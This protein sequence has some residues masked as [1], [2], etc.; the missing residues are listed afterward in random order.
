MHEWKKNE[1][2]KYK[3]KTEIGIGC[4]GVRTHTIYMNEACV[5]FHLLLAFDKNDIK[6]MVEIHNFLK[7]IKFSIWN[8]HAYIEMVHLKQGERVW[9]VNGLKWISHFVPLNNL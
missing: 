5:M 7:A 1:I 8:Y 2:K 6:Q 4:A 3:L 9:F